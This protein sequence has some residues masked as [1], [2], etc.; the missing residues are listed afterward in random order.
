[1]INQAIHTLDLL[2]WFL[3]HP[4]SVRGRAATLALAAAIEVAD[5]ARLVRAVGD[6]GAAGVEAVGDADPVK[7]T[8]LG[9]KN[10]ERVMGYLKTAATDPLSDNSDLQELYNRTV[11]QWANEAAHVATMVSGA[12]VRVRVAKPLE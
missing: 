3:G 9:F 4:A 8:T 6:A 2:T 10:I 12:S 7:A 11:G 1:M 5:I